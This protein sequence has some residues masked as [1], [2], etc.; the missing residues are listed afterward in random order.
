MNIAVECYADEKLVELLAYKNQV[1]VIHRSGKGNIF[2]YLRK[3]TTASAIGLVDEDPDSTQP[4]DLVKSYEEAES[5]GNVKRFSH[6]DKK[7]ISVIMLCPR[8]EEWIISRAKASGLNLSEY[9]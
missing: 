7:D 6:K 9:G 5:S 2:N 8:L 1:H 4:G 3:G